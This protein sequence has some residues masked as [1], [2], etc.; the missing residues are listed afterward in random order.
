VLDQ[1][2]LIEADFSSEY[3]IELEDVFL[4]RS[5]RWFT[6]KVSGLLVAETRLARYFRP[7]PETPLE[8]PSE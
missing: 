6:V 4:T 5:W 8:A 3:G 7:D 2:P 1:W